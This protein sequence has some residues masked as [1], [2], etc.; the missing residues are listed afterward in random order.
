MTGIGNDYSPLLWNMTVQGSTVME[1]SKRMSLYYTALSQE[2]PQNA[3]Q[4]L[5]VCRKE[6]KIDVINA[7][8]WFGG[9]KPQTAKSSFGGWE[10]AGCCVTVTVSLTTEL[11]KRWGGNRLAGEAKLDVLTGKI[12]PAF[13]VHKLK[14]SGRLL[15]GRR[16][17]CRV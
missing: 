3:S 4:S 14:L 10:W 6:I 5:P 17:T 15:A 1:H 16:P 12:L 11:L 13:T 8:W 9:R 7:W 2:N